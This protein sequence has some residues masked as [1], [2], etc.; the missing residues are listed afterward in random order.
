MNGSSFLNS[1]ASTDVPC[2]HHRAVQM[3]ADPNAPGFAPVM[4]GYGGPMY[5]SPHAGTCALMERPSCCAVFGNVVFILALNSTQPSAQHVRRLRSHFLTRTTHPSHTVPY[6]EVVPPGPAGPW[7][8]PGGR[9]PMPM[10]NAGPPPFRDPLP[11]QTVCSR[12]CGSAL[13]AHR[14][15]SC[16]GRTMRVRTRQRGRRG[17]DVTPHFPHTHTPN[18][19]LPPGSIEIPGES[20]HG[21]GYAPPSQGGQLAPGNKSSSPSGGATG[22]SAADKGGKDGGSEKRGAHQV[23][24]PGEISL[25]YAQP[26]WPGPE[27]EMAH[28]HPPPP[29]EAMG[30]PHY[31]CTLVSPL[32]LIELFSAAVENTGMANYASTSTMLIPTFVHTQGQPMMGPPG[33]Y[34]PRPPHFG[35]SSLSLLVNDVFASGVASIYCSA[36]YCV[37]ANLLHF[38]MTGP[39]MPGYGVMGPPPPGVHGPPHPMAMQGP[40]PPYMVCA[41]HRAPVCPRIMWA[42]ISLLRQSLGHVLHT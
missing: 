30:M 34:G 25:G 7:A 13:T 5:M 22:E 17:R 29:P 2:R 37:R 11:P 39:P 26:A 9:P 21:S 6:P 28:P 36:S 38:A 20:P 23:H 40:P 8:Y 18:A 15:P 12:A 31:V 24:I 1:R 41:G 33:P 14:V 27:F 42:C 35:V 32:R 16:E 19:Q 10:R 4:Y 3:Y